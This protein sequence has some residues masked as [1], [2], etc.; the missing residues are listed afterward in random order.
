MFIWNFCSSV[1]GSPNLLVFHPC[2]TH[3]N[4]IFGRKGTGGPADSQSKGKKTKM[5]PVLST[6]FFKTYR[7]TRTSFK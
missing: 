4:S 6:C 7:V 1:V 2:S 3:M 5:W